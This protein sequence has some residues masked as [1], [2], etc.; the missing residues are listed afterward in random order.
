MH[1]SNSAYDMIKNF[2]KSRQSLKETLQRSGKLSPA[3]HIT[4][5]ALSV[6]LGEL[7]I[8]F[9]FMMVPKLPDLYESIIDATLLTILLAPALYLF[10]FLPLSNQIHKL[11]KTEADLTLIQK[12]L[13]EQVLERS[14]QLDQ[15]K[16]KFRTLFNT[17]PDAIMLLNEKGFVDCNQSALNLFK[18]SSIEEFITYHPSQLSPIY[19]YDGTLSTTLSN[20]KIKAAYLNGDNRFEWQHKRTDGSIFDAEVLLKRVQIEGKTL[21]QATVRDISARKKNERFQRTLFEI[22][23]AANNTSSLKELIES[24][25]D[26]IHP[27]IDTTNFFMSLYDGETGLYTIP[28]IYGEEYEQGSL[29]ARALKGSLTDYVRRQ[30]EPV[31]INDEKFLLLQEAGLVSPIGKPTACWMGVPLKADKKVFG[32]IA[33]QDYK[34]PTAFTKEDV[35]TM[36]YFAQ[37]ISTVIIQKK[38]EQNLKKAKRD[39]EKVSKLKD[40]F[41]ASMSHEIRTPM[42]GV[43]GM[44]ELLE[45]TSLDEEQRGYTD[46]IHKSANILLR[47]INDILDFSKIEAGKIVLEKREFDLHEFIDNT[48]KFFQKDVSKKAIKL[49]RKIGTKVPTMVIGDEVRLRQILTNLIG[50]AI[51]FTDKGSV[52]L[53]VRQINKSPG[54]HL[55]KFEVTDSGIGID[56]HLV[57]NLFN[58]FTQADSSTT[59]KYGG[60]GL[61]LAISKNLTELMDGEMGVKSKPGLGSTFWFTIP[62]TIRKASSDS[63]IKPSVAV[64]EK[65]GQVRKVSL[66]T[67]IKI[68]VADDNRINQKVA[69][70]ILGKFGCQVTVAVNGQDAIKAWQTQPFDII[71]MDLEMPEMDGY[72][73]TTSIREKESADNHIPIIALTANAMQGVKDKCIATGMDD[74]LSKPFKKEELKKMLQKYA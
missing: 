57:D 30:G 15:S 63:A 4:F 23:Y 2:G 5:L 17:A 1:N 45:D 43:L 3:R 56:P 47:I 50:N 48:L 10:S 7:L 40:E 55:L 8:M 70:N 74:F 52:E 51:K 33:V 34:N 18:V 44:I 6:F 20:E 73:A 42:N 53:S 31:I 39:A 36:Q 64:I 13:K 71:L 46:I 11:K 21:L 25:R 28:V 14:Q 27:I 62:F 49:N 9:S 16:E 68:L 59:R 37:T 60:S 12:K 69:V 58:S 61:G 54:R 65:S 29:T 67:T 35:E 41:L 22:S 19:Q 72:E 24:I 38:A 32:I 66:L 26:K